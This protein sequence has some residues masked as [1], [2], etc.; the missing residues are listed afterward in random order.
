MGN[1]YTCDEKW[2][3]LVGCFHG[4]IMWRAWKTRKRLTW[5][6]C[7]SSVWA[8][9][10]FSMLALISLLFGT[11]SMPQA[12]MNSKASVLPL[13][14]RKTMVFF[15]FSNLILRIRS[16]FRNLSS[17]SIY[18]APFL[19][20]LPEVT[21]LSREQWQLFCITGSTMIWTKRETCCV[22]FFS[23]SPS[24]S[25]SWCSPLCRVSSSVQLSQ[26]WAFPL[27]SVGWVVSARTTHPRKIYG[28]TVELRV[29]SP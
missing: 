19:W 8:T 4:I 3:G 16:F 13:V 10:A 29:R 20:Q 15:S 7:L 23:C 6:R 26:Y 11:Q 21:A 9:F 18:I 22:V 2:W 12:C 25:F 24:F 17:S 28:S 1:T 5:E 14:W 27:K